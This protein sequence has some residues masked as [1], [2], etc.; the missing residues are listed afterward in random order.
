MEIVEFD[1]E[2]DIITYGNRE[3]TGGDDGNRIDHR[4]PAGDCVW[5]GKRLSRAARWYDSVRLD[6]GRS[7]FAGYNP[8]TPEMK[9]RA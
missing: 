9:L 4:D 2:D 1:V 5:R 8:C 3:E 6:P 7:D